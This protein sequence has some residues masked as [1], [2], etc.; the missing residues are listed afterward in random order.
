MLDRLH[1]RHWNGC[2]QTKLDVIAN[3]LAKRDAPPLQENARRFSGSLVRK[4]FA[5]PRSPMR[6]GAA[7][8]RRCRWVWACARPPHRAPSPGRYDRDQK[9]ARIWPSRAVLLPLQRANGDIA[10]TRR[11]QF[12]WMPPDALSPSLGEVL[13]PGIT[14]PQMD[15]RSTVTSTAS[16]R[17][18][19]PI[20]PT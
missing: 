14:I 10:F 8:P 11:W 2:Q 18:D 20:V 1:S 6:R 7:S 3:N 5:Q 13:E 12:D 17:P 15:P 9:P 4:P 19:F 16:C